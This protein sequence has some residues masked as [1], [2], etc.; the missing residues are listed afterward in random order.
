MNQKPETSLP[1]TFV[2]LSLILCLSCQDN[3]AQRENHKFTNDLINETSPYLQQHAHNPVNW[4]PWGDTIF[5]EAKKENKLVII[6][7]GYSSCH[8]CH[9]MEEETFEDEKV[10]EIMNRDFIAV[11]VDREERPDVDQVYMTAVQ[12]MTG[13]GGWPLNIIALP[14]GKP[15]YGGTY[16]SNTQWTKVIQKIHKLYNDDP[17]KANE[18]ADLVAQGIQDANIV[19]PTATDNDLSK[20]TIREGVSKWK[21]HLDMKWGGNSG[22][23]K[24]ML[25]AHFDFLL[26]YA[27]LANDTTSL[28]FVKTTLDQM[29]QGGIYDHIAGGFYR[30]STDAHWE[31]P[32]FEKMLY[33]NA[34]LVSFYSKAYSVFKDPV[35]KRVATETIAFLQKEMKSTD[36]GYFAAIDADSEGEEGKYY[37][38]TT[39]E[40]QGLI[41]NDY[42]LFTEYF[43][44]TSSKKMEGGKIVLQKKQN[45]T[46][47]AKSHGMTMDELGEL[48]TGWKNRLLDAR[49][50]RARPRI[51]DKV[52]VSW[53]ALLINAYV[54][55]YKAFGDIAYLNEGKHI[56]NTIKSSAYNDKHL[57]HSYKKGSKRDKGFLEDYAFLAN[58]SVNLYTASLDQSHLDFAQELILSS[59]DQFKDEE[60]GFYK[61]NADN[62]LIAN[63][64]KNDD[65]VIPSPN[66]VMAHT[67]FLLGHIEYN[68]DYM[69]SAKTMLLSLQPQLQ[70]VVQG[71]T[72]W[73]SLQLKMTYPYYEIAVVGS[74]ADAVRK[75]L[76]QKHLPNTLIV[77]STQE[78]NLP[79]F[80]DRYISD[81]T[82]IYVCKGNMCK[83]PVDNVADAIG[84]LQDF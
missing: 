58:A 7:I 21:T 60:S 42:P 55:A 32:H 51:D 9:V 56:Y 61:F 54:D 69:D 47:F 72:H 28:S 38:W 3:S 84:Q 27:V 31:I 36:G 25:P 10:A 19:V 46:D 83:L 71:Y 67:L 30:Y 14:N 35:Y 78:S 75:E 8:W 52:I 81:G 63:I 37:V 64:I 48:T 15:M 62:M 16:H 79:L 22:S 49:E 73:A 76:Q 11:K 5:E 80:K 17:E 33:D 65:G 12:L 20:K 23:E 40:L 68:K 4:R 53:N 6:S 29:A 59:I 18:Y 34:Q 74:Q 77:S 13:E 26:D 50:K 45:N 1:V 82:F 24:F 43:N 41:K 2:L 70:E 57:I 44:T 66:A 39:E